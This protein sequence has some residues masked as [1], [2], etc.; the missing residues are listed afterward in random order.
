MRKYTIQTT[1]HGSRILFEQ[2]NTCSHLDFQIAPPDLHT[3]ILAAFRSPDKAPRAELAGVIA[4][5]TA[6]G[7]RVRVV[8]NNAWMDI[9][10]DIIA[11]DFV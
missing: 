9:P 11:R 4:D 2:M 5:R 10:W 7:V 6:N 3:L 1:P 8:A